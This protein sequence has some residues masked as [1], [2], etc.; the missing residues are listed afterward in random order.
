MLFNEFLTNIKSSMKQYDSVGLINDIAVYDWVIEGMNS[1][2]MLPTVRIEHIL[3]VKNNKAT[4]P[5]GFKSLYKAVKCEPYVVTI[6]DNDKHHKLQDFYFYKVRELKNEDWNF[7]NPC[8]IEETQTCVVE[9]TYLYNN[10]K[11][12]FYYNNLQPIKLKLTPYIKKT[13]CDIDCENFKVKES[14]NE[15]SINNKILN[16]N[17][18]EGNIFIVYNGYE[19]DDEGFIIIPETDENNIIRF[20]TAYVKKR[21]IEELLINSDNTTNEQFLYQMF[22]QEESI[23]FGKTV[24]ELKMKHIISSLKNYKKRLKKEFQIYNYGDS[25]H[26]KDMVGFIVL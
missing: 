21:I 12:N 15:I 16:A 1:L 24:G 11:S 8:D 14:P 7:C 23:Y 5:D 22:S 25:N 9:K 4:L 18:K 26:N 10:I 13:K 6:D 17:F 3:K 20:L 19:E 2:N